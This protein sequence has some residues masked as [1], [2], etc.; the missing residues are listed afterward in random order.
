MKKRHGHGFTLVEIIVAVAILGVITVPIMSV[1][2]RT[3]QI[4][5][6]ARN[7]QKATDLGQN[8]MEGIREYTMEE[9]IQQCLQADGSLKVIYSSIITYNPKE[10]KK[11]DGTADFT[12]SLQKAANSSTNYLYGELD[13]ATTYTSFGGDQY[14]FGLC[15]IQYNKSTFDATITFEKYVEESSNT[16]GNQDT[17]STN[18]YCIYNV[19]ITI[20]SSRE[21]AHFSSQAKLATLTGAVQNK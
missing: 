1:L 15:G 9:V 7:V 12:Q 17:S 8:L 11:L 5:A 10:Y 2:V 19:T 16:N 6:R 3:T 13:K 4:N 18:P 20:Y 14:N 21:G